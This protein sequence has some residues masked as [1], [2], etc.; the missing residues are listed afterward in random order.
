MRGCLA[1]KLFACHALPISCG[2]HRTVCRTLG[3]CTLLLEITNNLCVCIQLFFVVAVFREEGGGGKWN[4]DLWLLLPTSALRCGERTLEKRCS[5]TCLLSFSVAL[6]VHTKISR[7]LKCRKKCAFYNPAVCCFCFCR[8]AD[9]YILR[10]V[11]LAFKAHPLVR[12]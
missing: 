4:V 9:F 12:Q 8:V 2:A 3:H 10:E 11:W 7:N 5:S 1:P 6:K